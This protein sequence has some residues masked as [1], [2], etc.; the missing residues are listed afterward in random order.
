MS[1]LLHLQIE[2]G[3]PDPKLGAGDFPK[4]EFVLKGIK[5]D[6]GGAATQRH[7]LPITPAVLHRLRTVWDARLD[8]DKDMHMLWAASCMAFFGFLRSAEFTVPRDDGFDPQVHLALGDVAFDNLEDPSMVAVT[9]KASKTDPFRA[10]VT[11]YLG[12][13]GGLICPVA[14][15][16]AYLAVRPNHGGPLFVFKDGVP[17]TR[18]RFVDRVQEGLSAA[19]LDPRLYNGHS[20]RIGAAT[21]A[22]QQGVEDSTIQMMGRWRSSTYLRYIRTPREVLA[23]VSRR[24]VPAGP[25]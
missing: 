16:L 5:R 21:T 12:R 24:L 6:S 4:L 7:R 19:G 9:V 1:A 3:L 13:T 23:G 22:H 10:G 15:M 2:E 14:A 18:S 11:L 20:F 25:P 17:L 8:R